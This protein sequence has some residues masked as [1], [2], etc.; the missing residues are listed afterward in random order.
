[1]YTRP[2]TTATADWLARALRIPS[3]AHAEWAARGVALLPLGHRYDAVRIPAEVLL[4]AHPEPLPDALGPVVLDPYALRFYALVP[5]GTTHTWRS[6][7]A[8][9]LGRG[10]WI[11]V[12]HVERTQPPGLH[13]IAPMET[14]GDLCSPAMLSDLLSKGRDQPVSP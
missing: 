3:L 6:P 10:A 4:S 14:A 13:W 5:P 8:R 7:L 2:T 1:M 12:P 11:G 9:C